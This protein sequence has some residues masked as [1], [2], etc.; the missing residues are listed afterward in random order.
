VTVT[1]LPVEVQS[2]HEP[3]QTS[4]LITHERQSPQQI[5]SFVFGRENILDV[6]VHALIGNF[7]I[8]REN[9]HSDW[10]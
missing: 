1:K 2:L 3:A 5:W 9:G 10:N 8:A 6:P 4:P 7:V